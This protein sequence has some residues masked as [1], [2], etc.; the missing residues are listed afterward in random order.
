MSV[1]IASEFYVVGKSG[2]FPVSVEEMRNGIRPNRNLGDWDDV[3]VFD[4]TDLKV[5]VFDPNGTFRP[6]SAL[7]DPR[8]DLR[9]EER[10]SVIALLDVAKE[11]DGPAAYRYIQTA[12]LI[13][14]G[15]RVTLSYSDK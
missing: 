15:E 3:P 5:G 13:C 2:N 4:A 9:A 1:T 8:K 6:L 7:Y 11:M 12:I 10:G 14:Q